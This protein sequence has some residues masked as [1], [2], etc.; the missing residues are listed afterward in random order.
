M[1]VAIQI[2]A[3]V[4]WLPLNLLVIAALLRGDY[5][6]F[7]FILVYVLVEFLATAAEIPAYWAVFTHSPRGVDLQVYIYWMDEAIAQVLIFIVVMDLIYRATEKHRA[8]RILRIGLIVGAVSFAAI[9]LAIHY[10]PTRAGVWMTPWTRDL[11]FCAAILDLALWTILIAS[12]E[13]DRRL[14]LL[15]GALGIYFTGEA[16]GYSVMQLAALHRSHAIALFGSTLVVAADI[17]RSYIWLRVF[18]WKRSPSSGAY[19]VSKPRI[20]ASH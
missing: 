8:R 6:R 16:I 13:K 7:P 15:S 20:D 5:R 12:R 9:S 17:V 18:Q 14:L 11:N 3:L 2:A 4:I 1:E 19:L 10:K